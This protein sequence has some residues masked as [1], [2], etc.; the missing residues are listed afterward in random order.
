MQVLFP[1]KWLLGITDLETIGTYKLAYN[2]KK[3]T[4]FDNFGISG[5][6]PQSIQKRCVYLENAKCQ[7]FDDDCSSKFRFICQTHY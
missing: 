2:N 5:K 1:G 6:S 4:Y 3:V 7:L